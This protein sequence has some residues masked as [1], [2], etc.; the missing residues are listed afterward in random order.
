M[1][2]HMQL[3]GGKSISDIYVEIAQEALYDRNQEP[4]A[5]EIFLHISN[6]LSKLEQIQVRKKHDRAAGKQYQIEFIEKGQDF[7]RFIRAV[8]AVPECV[9]ST[10]YQNY[11]DYMPRRVADPLIYEI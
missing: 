4:A 6:E 11:L 8:D 10:H 3:M 1:Q 7:F 9:N 2:E 5:Q